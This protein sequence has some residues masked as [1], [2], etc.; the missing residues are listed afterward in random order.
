MLV[1][2]HTLLT[3]IPYCGKRYCGS[4]WVGG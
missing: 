2:L 1:K 3:Y 4:I